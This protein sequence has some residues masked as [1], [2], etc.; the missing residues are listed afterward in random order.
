MVN[1]FAHRGFW[2]EYNQ[3]NTIASLKN[4]RESAFD[5][6]ECDLFFHESRGLLLSHDEVK[7]KDLSNFAQY[8]QYENFFKYW[9]DFKNLDLVNA[10]KVFEI[11][12]SEVMKAKIN[13]NN[14]FIAPFISDYQLARAIL[15]IAREVFE[16]KLNFAAMCK[17]AE[18]EDGLVEFIHEENIKFLSIAH[19]LINEKLIEKLK[20]VELFVWTINDLER[21]IYLEK[22]GIKN[23]ITDKI[24]PQIY[25]RYIDKPRT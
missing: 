1:L 11:V 25:A 10:R 3:Q 5:G 9:L 19:E 14:I 18:E 24:T 8:L 15:K 2:H 23:F 6:I 7:D 22:F 13:F 21:I 12:K 17:C 4:A 20:D 16:E